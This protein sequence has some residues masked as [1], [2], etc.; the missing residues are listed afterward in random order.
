MRTTILE[1][2]DYSNAAVMLEACHTEML[3]GGFEQRAAQ[4]RGLE[5]FSVVNAKCALETLRCMEPTGNESIDS[6]ARHAMAV[7]VAL[8]ADESMAQA[9]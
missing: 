1:S 9:S 3:R 7:L 5:I 6:A 2:A 8:I 4:L